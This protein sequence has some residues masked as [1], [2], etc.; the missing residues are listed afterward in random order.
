MLKTLFFSNY[1]EEEWDELVDIEK[2]NKSDEEKSVSHFVI[3]NKPMYRIFTI[4]DIEELKGF[5]GDWIV[6][7]KYNGVRVQLHK[8][9]NNIKVFKHDGTEI[10]DKCPTQVKE[11]KEKKYGPGEIVFRVIKNYFI[12]FFINKLG[13]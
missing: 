9:D 2:S 1:D 5:T 3:P 8:I 6:Q 12:Y 4:K 11:L 13:K 10:T 7:E